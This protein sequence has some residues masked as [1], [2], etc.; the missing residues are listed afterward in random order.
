MIT[1]TLNRQKLLPDVTHNL[2]HAGVCATPVFMGRRQYRLDEFFDIEGELS[3]QIEIH[4][5][6]SKMKSI[7]RGMSRGKIVVHGDAGMH[8]GAQMTG[9]E[10]NVTGSAADWAGA[11]MRGGMIRIGGDAGGQI[12]AAYRGDAAGMRGG[13]I[14]IEGTAGQEVGM[15]MKRGTIVV[16]GKV[17]DFAGLQMKGGTIVLLRGAGARPGSW[18]IRGTILSLVELPLLPT[19]R[20]ASRGTPTFLRLY[21]QHLETLGAP[22]PLDESEGSWNR[23]SGDLSVP[24]KGEVLVW[25]TGTSC[26]TG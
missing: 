21:A 9:G 16:R 24:G 15:R 8:L 3:D 14:V 22:I 17:G 6:T 5:T 13:T 19:F 25:R 18:M 2:E 1:L 10:I 4:G 26:Q 20:Y 23:Y 7:G 12:G 11:E